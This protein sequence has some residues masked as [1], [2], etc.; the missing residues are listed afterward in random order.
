VGSISI[1]AQQQAAAALLPCAQ[2]YGHAPWQRPPRVAPHPRCTQ[3]R[4]ISSPAADWIADN[5]KHG[6]VTKEKFMGGSGWSSTYVYTT[7]DGAE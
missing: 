5:L 1:H 2:E 6:Y 4:S 7:E 3:C